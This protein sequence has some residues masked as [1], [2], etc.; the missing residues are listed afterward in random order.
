M[1]QLHMS[2]S[3]F[4]VSGRATKQRCL[5]W[6][7]E[8]RTL[9]WCVNNNQDMV[10]LFT[11]KCM[12]IRV[13]DWDHVMLFYEVW[14]WGHTRTAHRSH[15]IRY[16]TQARRKVFLGGTSHPQTATS[17]D[18]QCWHSQTVLGMDSLGTRL[19]RNCKASLALISG[20]ATLTEGFMWRSEATKETT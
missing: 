11:T 1:K 19:T 2:S 10:P 4:L 3:S 14:E 20:P 7:F 12:P 8:T 13:H 17:G 15:I 18:K 9:M 5:N 6:M 16:N